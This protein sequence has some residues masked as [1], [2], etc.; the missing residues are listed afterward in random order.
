MK[1]QLQIITLGAILAATSGL[2]LAKAENYVPGFTLNN[3]SYSK[4]TLDPRTPP[5]AT[6]NVPKVISPTSFAQLSIGSTENQ[7][8]DQIAYDVNGSSSN[9][10][11]I[12]FKFVS[13]QP[14]ID[15]VGQSG[16]V[17]C[18]YSGSSITV[19]SSV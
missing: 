16:S 15:S 4:L 14:Y 1:K 5:A 3:A 7:A 9:Y 13:G 12:K 8:Y 11:L 19:N 6:D 18:S 2:A 17:T 10:C